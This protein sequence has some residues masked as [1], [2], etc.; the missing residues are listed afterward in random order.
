MAKIILLWPVNLKKTKFLT[1]P[2]LTM[3]KLFIVFSLVVATSFA[4]NAQDEGFTS[5]NGHQ[6][7]PEAGDYSV[8]I[9]AQPFL[10]YA[11]NLFSGATAPTFN[12]PASNAITLRKFIDANTA[13]RAMIRFDL[14][15]TTSKYNVSN[16]T[17]TDPNA[18]VTD[19]Y[20]AKN[21]NIIIG[22]GLE[23]R[24]G[25]SRVQGIYGA[26]VTL[27]ISGGK[28]VYTYGNSITSTNTNP[29]SH[30]FNGNINGATRTL[31][32]KTGSGISFGV[33]GFVGAEFFIAPKLSLGGEFQWGP[34][35]QLNGNL[36]TETEVWDGANNTVKKTTTTTA[37]GSSFGLNTINTQINLNFFF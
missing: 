21:T 32:Q 16:N 28:D 1:K 4:A 15:S 18:T 12:F 36:K 14:G 13:Y 11:G 23:K 30:N 7:L 31:S 17:S 37:G 5:K 24:K 27:G 20:S 26:M 19:K 22:A 3:K 2:L 35:L 34:Q 25:T 6:V 33:V 10:Q 29:T 8:A 9:D